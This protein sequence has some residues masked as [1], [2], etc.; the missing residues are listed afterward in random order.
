MANHLITVFGG[1]GFLGRNIV[2]HLVVSEVAVRIVARHPYVPD[3]AGSSG[4]IEL[5]TANIRD[6]ASVAAAVKGATG[7]VNAV[8]LYVEKG[9]ATFE[10]IHVEGAER[11]AQ[12]TREAGIRKLVHISGIGADPASPSKYV[13]ARAHGEQ[14][15]RN[16]LSDAVILRPSVLFGPNDA[17]LS[18]LKT[19]TRLPV[20]PLFGQGTTRLQPVYVEDVARAV[21]QALEKPGTAGQIFELG[22]AGIYSYRDL[23]AR[24]LAHLGRRR[25]LLPVPFTAWRLLARIASLLPNAPLTVD[26][27]MLME[28]ANVVGAGVGTFA[29]LGIEP[30]SLE[31]MLPHCLGGSPP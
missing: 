4:Q 3:L 15:V 26:Q 20:V 8:G 31:Q 24:V 21:R 9:E 5:Q 16:A 22:G 27:V 30:R 1:T 2:H 28:T 17:F 6:P 11:V 29:D 25:P 19:V 14:R 18:S 12:Q 7:V 23:V 10:A 13:R